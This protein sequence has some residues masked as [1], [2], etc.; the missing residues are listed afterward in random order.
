M[1]KKYGQ[2]RNMTKKEAKKRIENLKRLINYHRYLYHVLDREEISPEALDSL[3]HELYKLEQEFPEFITS[4]SPT[5]R[6]AGEPLPGFKKVEHKVP[7]L[8]IEDIFSEEELKDWEDYLKKLVP[9]Q[10]FEYFAELKFDGFAISLV[11]KNGIFTYGSTRGT[12]LLGENVTQN[13]KTIESIPLKLEIHN[14]LPSKEIEEKVKKLIKNGEIEIRG[15]VYISVRDFERLNK[16]VKRRGGKTFAN[17]RNLAAGSIRQLDPKLAASRPLKFLAYDIITDFGQKKHS[18]EHQILPVL[19]FKTDQGKVCKRLDEVIEFWKE[20]AKKREKLPFQIDGIVININDN[21]IFQ[22]FG[23]VGKSPRGVRA[24]KFSPKQAT[25]ILENVKFQVGRTGAVTPVAVLKPVEVGGVKISKATLHNEDEIK[26]LEVKIGDTVIVGRA[27]DV[28][29]EVIQALPE[30][31]TG[32]ER[33]INFPR[34]CPICGQKLE[35]LEGEAIW[36]CKNPK[37]PAKERRSLYHFVSKGT[38]DIV[39]LGPKIIDRLL[40]EGL[41]QYP[42]DL[43]ELEEGDLISLER[44]GEKSVQNIIGSIERAK[45]VSLSRFIYALGIRHVG[46]ETA[47]DLANYFGS[48]EKIKKASFEEINKISNVGD[49]IAKSI[50]DWFKNKENL[51]L[52]DGLIRTG[53][54]IIKPEKIEAKLKGLTFIFTGTLKTITRDEAKEKVRLLGGEIFSSVSK[55]TDFLVLGE[56]PGSK[57]EKAKELGVKIVSEEEFLKMIK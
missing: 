56:E 50:C 41:V 49:V 25:T 12:G 13:L 15:E 17:P 46:K 53:V 34:N 39:G 18:Q 45:N 28:I 10:K 38:F 26:K 47:V 6:V 57:Y 37:C 19:G 36:R 24:F 14:K 20:V 7:M 51:K 5:Q 54:K 42:A 48:I 55:E 40:D 27:G 23:V 1:S 30:L 9:G 35:K 11:Y 32:K 2:K 33:E 16:E 21:E 3:K 22:N 31:R 8:S 4:D 43:F 44:F 29:P 52:I